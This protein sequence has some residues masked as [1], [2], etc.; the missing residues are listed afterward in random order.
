MLSIR[1]VLCPVDL[2]ASTARQ[3]DVAVDL[4]RAF[5][6]RLILLHNQIELAIGA[7]VGWMWRPGHEQPAAEQK[8]QEVQATLPAGIEV[9]ARLTR[10]PIVD[11]IVVVSRE[12][13]ADLVVLGTRSAESDDDDSVTDRLLESNSLPI[14]AI[15]D[16]RHEHR[17][18][19]FAAASG[20]PQALLVPL[21]FTPAS[22]PA[23]DVAFDLSRRFGFDVHLLHVLPQGASND[24]AEEAARRKMAAVVP[25]DL[26]RRPHE[27]IETGVPA[28]AIARVADRV[29]AVCIVMGEH[30]RT[31]MR[32][33]FRSDT[34]KAVLHPS[35]C[36]VWYVP[37]P[38]PVDDAV[39]QP[40]ERLV[41]ELQ[42]TSFHYWPT[43]YLHGVVDSPEE[44]ESTLSDMIK[45]GIAKDQ[46]HTWHGPNGSAAIDPTGEKHGRMARLWRTLEKATPER[47]LFER[48]ASEI[49]AG[50]VCIGVQIASP[51]GVRVLADILKQHGGHLISYFSVG[52]VQHLWPEATIQNPEGD[53]FRTEG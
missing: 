7:G 45:V 49:E 18:P 2:S 35:P 17:T 20:S 6:A 26:M 42:D 52:T 16:A 34:S 29:A 1:T 27:H 28:R 3:V 38:A 5:G 25:P 40:G 41:E 21:D 53:T 24:H 12:V 23:V 33:W 46:L 39:V 13:S 30:V 31:P 43:P 32:H 36:P 8:L 19:A 50:H 44:A 47:E 37:G 48:Y 51:E 10:G 15:H 11:A 14:F 4:C 22:R 9:E